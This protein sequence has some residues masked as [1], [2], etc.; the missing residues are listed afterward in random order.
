VV[1]V[2]NIFLALAE[3][4]ATGRKR[5]KVS[6][7]K[8]Y[9]SPTMRDVLFYAFSP[10]VSFGVGRVS[11]DSETPWDPSNPPSIGEFLTLCKNLSDRS[12][13][14]NAAEAAV[15]A[16]VEQY[17]AELRE[18]V[19]AVFAARLS[20]G[21]DVEIINSALPGVIPVFG[22]QLAREFNP[23]HMTYPAYASAKLDG[24]RCLLF[25]TYSGV[26]MHTRTG[27]RIECLP[28][29]ES[30]F[31]KLPLGVYDG[32]LLHENGVFSD[33]I[34][35]CRKN[36]P[37]AGSASIRFHVFDYISLAEW[38]SPITPASQRFARLAEIEH[39][40]LSTLTSTQVWYVVPHV[41]VNSSLELATLHTS[42]TASGYEGTMVQFNKPYNKKRTYD[43]MK[44]KDF[45]STE[46]EVIGIHMGTGKFKGMIG[47]LQCRDTKTRME[48]KCGSGFSDEERRLPHDYWLGSVIEVQ[49]QELTQDN[50]PRFPTFLRRRDDL[51][52]ETS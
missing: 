30:A 11:F 43:L 17:P 26:S 15:R 8:K 46:A 10:T 5:E 3:I 24:M 20:I 34:S 16:H 50:I 31:S 37:S 21:C 13:T 35:V 1:P 47:A 40:Y 48:F 29:I 25:V 38:D 32:E 23:D 27:K 9:D 49:Y 39:R 18:L 14:G 33:T 2:V 42:L 41:L 12:L 22:V 7:L 28:A 44:L 45:L 51:L 4:K 36:E 19:A 52:G 6:L